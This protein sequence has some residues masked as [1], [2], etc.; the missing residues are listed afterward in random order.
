MTA[1]NVP[2][3]KLGTKQKQN[4]IW[5]LESIEQQKLKGKNRYKCVIENCDKCRERKEAV[6]HM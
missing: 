1:N 4:Q 2:G 6:R 5:I 3:P